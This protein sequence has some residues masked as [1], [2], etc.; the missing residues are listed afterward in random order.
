MLDGN[1]PRRAELTFIS[2]PQFKE[3]HMKHITIIL[4][5]FSFLGLVSLLPFAPTSSHAIPVIQEVLYDGQ[6]PDALD[7]FTEIFGDPG[8]SLHGWSLVGVNGSDGQSY[9]TVTLDGTVIPK[10]GILLITTSTAA[11]DLLVTGDFLG[12]VDWQN[13]PDAVQLR[14]PE[15]KIIDA[16]QYGDAGVNNAGEGTPAI[17]VSP[18]WSLSRDLFG[19]DTDD[20]LADFMAAASPTPGKGPIPVSEP[21]TLA[22]LTSSILGLIA[23][24][25]KRDKIDN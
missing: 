13:G 7:A 8:M 2:K 25:R 23:Y 22:L 1:T 24:G 16:L 11:S 20:N 19:T 14:D 10:D 3:A 6:G 21:A 5:G 4:A 12:E 9:R 15:G 18:G 17:D